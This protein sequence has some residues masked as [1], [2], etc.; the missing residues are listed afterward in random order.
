MCL[1]RLVWAGNASACYRSLWGPSGPK[2]PGSV[3]ESVPENRGCP[4]E[5]PAGC[6]SG[7]LGPALWI[8]QEVSRECQECVSGT[9]RDTSGTKHPRDAC[10]RPTHSSARQISDKCRIFVSTFVV[11]LSCWTVKRFARHSSLEALEALEARNI[12]SKRFLFKLS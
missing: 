4:R 3:S 7:P 10:S 6:L 5:C 11:N 12:P 8:V 9:L 1:R 2:C